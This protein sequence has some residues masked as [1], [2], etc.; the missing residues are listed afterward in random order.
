MDDLVPHSFGSLYEEKGKSQ[1]TRDC[2]LSPSVEVFKRCVDA[3]FRD[4]V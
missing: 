1:K 4:L 3:A 2:T